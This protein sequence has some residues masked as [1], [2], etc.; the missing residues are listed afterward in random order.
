MMM[1]AELF[2]AALPGLVVLCA[3]AL[4]WGLSRWNSFVCGIDERRGESE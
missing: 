1:L 2:S 3:L 4:L